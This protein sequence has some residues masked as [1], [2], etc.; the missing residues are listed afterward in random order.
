MII[1]EMELIMIEL[2]SAIKKH[3]VLGLIHRDEGAIGLCGN[4]I[5]FKI[6]HR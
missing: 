1:D 6:A 3:F 5:N 4:S 2:K